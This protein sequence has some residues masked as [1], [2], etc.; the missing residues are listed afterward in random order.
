MQ[1]YTLSENSILGGAQINYVEKVGDG[2][3]RWIEDLTTDLVGTENAP[4]EFR[5][6]SAMIQKKH[7]NTRI[8]A[9]VNATVIFLVPDS[10]E[11]GIQAIVNSISGAIVTEVSNG[12]IGEYQNDDGSIRKFN[13]GNDIAVFQDRT[14][15]TLYRFF[16][17][18]FL[19][20]PIK[21]VVGLAITDAS[22]A[23]AGLPQ[24]TA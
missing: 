10:G 22:A 20:Y 12:N 19:R 14:Q 21:R 16:V 15:R 24:E 18:Y 8:Q 4:D 2:I 23:A 6:I 11:A 1:V 17:G 3:F 7:M 5:I 9:A 13:A